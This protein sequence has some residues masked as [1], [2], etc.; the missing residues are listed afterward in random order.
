MKKILIFCLLWA[1][2]LKGTECSAQTPSQKPRILIYH[3]MEGLSG[4][5]DWRM[6]SYSHPEQYKIG[7]EL[8]TA[9]VNAVIGGLFEGGAG[10]VQVVDAHGSGN[11]DPDLLLDKLD[12]RAS[13][14]SRDQP[15]RQYVDIVEP[16]VYDAVVCVGMHAKTGSGGFASHTFTLG[17]DIILNDLSVTETEL[18]A[19]SWGRVGV[20]VIFVSGDDKLADDLRT[21][22]W[23]EY[24]SV[25]KATS[26]ST[27]ELRPWAEVRRDLFDKA[28]KSIRNI[29]MATAMKL[30]EPIKATLRVVPPA[31]VERLRNMPGIDYK[32]NSATFM[33]ENF[34]KAY[35]GVIAM[36]GIATTGY[37]S[38][39]TEVI[40]SLPNGKA[41]QLQI[42]DARYNRWLDFESGRW[43]PEPLPAPAPRKYYGAR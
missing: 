10:T 30:N 20:P 34:A 13:M 6:F 11:Q 35:D 21:M 7:R 1:V 3:D 18:V 33:A 16:N 29:P 24:V 31:S 15:F 9:D 25:K 19:Y 42:D 8:L 23:I 32:E 12:K 5:N 26:A 17:M 36:I 22:P 38:M 14:V 27:V 39:T 2:E 4:E 28:A 41:V 43:K 40:K 37:Y